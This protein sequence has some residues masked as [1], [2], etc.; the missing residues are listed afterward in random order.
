M[1]VDKRKRKRMLSNRKSANRS[2]MR[3]QKQLEDLTDEVTKLEEAIKVK[4]WAIQVG[5][6]LTVVVVMTKV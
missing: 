5:G 2:R 3:K 4:A 1:M 6:V